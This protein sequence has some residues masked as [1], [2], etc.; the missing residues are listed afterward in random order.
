[1]LPRVLDTKVKNILS[2]ERSLAKAVAS[3]IL[4][5]KP[6]SVWE[7]MIPILFLFN[8]FQYKRARE[9]FS[10]NFLFTKKM[11]LEA[12]FGIIDKGKA[13]EQAKAEIKEKTDKILAADAKGIYSSKIR[14]KQMKEIDL[15]MEHYGRLLEADG[16]DFASMVKKSYRTRENYCGFLAQLS[17]AEKEVNRAAA[18]TVRTHSAAEIVSKMEAAVQAFRKAEVERI[19][20]LDG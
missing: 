16:K 5:F 14:Q 8:F 18:Q 17:E 6:P 1:M 2:W 20:R 15:L 7:I 3:S 13:K 19:F 9:T 12:A 11:A 4:E 10:L